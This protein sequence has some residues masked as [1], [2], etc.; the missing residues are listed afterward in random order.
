MSQDGHNRFFITSD[1]HYGV[2]KKGDR[3]TELLADYVAQQEA[4]ALV[5][6]GDIGTGLET[7]AACLELFSDFKGARMAVVGNHDVWTRGYTTDDS[8]YIHEE[9]LPALFW[10]KGFHPLHLEPCT[11]NNVTFTGSMG[12]YDY[13]FRDDIGIELACY[14]SKIPPWSSGPIWNDARYTKFNLSDPELTQLLLKRFKDQLKEARSSEHI[15]AVTHHVV[16]KDLLVH[17]RWLV[18]IRWRY[19]NAFLG[20]ECFG[21]LLEKERVK[22]VFC[23][24]IHREKTISKKGCKWTTIGGDYHRKQLIEATPERIISKRIFS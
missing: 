6:A 21:D 17:P 2:S 23:G 10:K 11:V 4:I 7:T 9:I 13:S 15:V 18:P 20:S 3:S 19:A 5:I 24:H 8:W 14:K 12:W 1:L 16:S 22:Q